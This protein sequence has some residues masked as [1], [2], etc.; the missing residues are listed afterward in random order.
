M[1]YRAVRR[2]MSEL[3]DEE[4]I[5]EL[6]SVAKVGYLGLSDEE[7]TYVVPLNYVWTE[8][9]IYFHGSDQGRKVD[10]MQTSNRI[11]F[12]VSEDR[13]TITNPTPADIGTAYTSVMVFGKVRKVES[14]EESTR[15]LQ[16]LL[17]KFVPGYFER[18]LSEKYVDSY[19]SSLGSKT[20]VYRIE[21]DQITAKEE[22]SDLSKIFFPGRKQID[23]LKR[24]D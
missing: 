16:A 21:P 12:T 14:L 9:K 19:R 4:R 10:A 8:N 2:A 22:V 7:G 3:K 1:N 23:D 18:E 13:G 15:A 24:K 20:T 17:D 6:L 5:N 11:C